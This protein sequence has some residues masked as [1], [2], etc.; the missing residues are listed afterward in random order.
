MPQRLL[1]F[2]IALLAFPLTVH[3]ANAEQSF[4]CKISGS[5]HHCSYTGKVRTAYVREDNVILM[6]FEQPIDLSLP[7]TVGI[8][9]VTQASARRINI[10]QRPVFAEYFY[11]TIL[12]AQATGRPVSLLFDQQTAGY[13]KI[14]RIWLHE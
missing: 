7:P 14:D 12:S 5:H 8:E 9:G 2:F 10:D 3:Q 4:S 6:Y 11:S 1:T 13:L